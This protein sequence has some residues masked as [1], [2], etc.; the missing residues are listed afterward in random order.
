MSRTCP[1]ELRVML[2]RA[3]LSFI[4]RGRN[5]S[6]GFFIHIFVFPRTR[7]TLLGRSNQTDKNMG[8][9]FSRLVFKEST[10]HRMKGTKIG[11]ISVEPCKG[12][13]RHSGEDVWK[14]EEDEGGNGS[15][16]FNSGPP[17]CGHSPL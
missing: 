9:P 2:R 11:I 12:S 8:F 5:L 16:M 6:G 15:V 1:E 14:R 3:L 17:L 13:C 7:L 4:W 10:G